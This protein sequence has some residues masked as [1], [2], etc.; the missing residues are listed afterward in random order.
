MD[1]GLV[2]RPVPTDA[3]RPLP[4]WDSFAAPAALRRQGRWRDPAS[5]NM[6]V[7]YVAHGLALAEALGRSGPDESRPRIHP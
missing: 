4:L 3:A 6:P 7:L 2:A 5:R 1:D